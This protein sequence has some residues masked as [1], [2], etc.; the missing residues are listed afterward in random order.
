MCISSNIPLKMI[1]YVGEHFVPIA[2]SFICKIF[3]QL[4]IVVVI[5]TVEIPQKLVLGP[6][7]YTVT[8]MIYYCYMIYTYQMHL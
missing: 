4:N 7:F 8:V 1:A 6:D 5:N 2:C 3:M